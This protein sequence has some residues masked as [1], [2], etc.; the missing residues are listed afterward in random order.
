MKTVRIATRESPLALWQANHVAS[1]LTQRNPGLE[2]TL[3]KMTTEGDRFLS[4]P[5]SQVGGKGLFVKE[6]EQ[7]LIDGRADVAVHSLKDMTSVFP[8]GLILAA[9]PTRE[10]PRD[11]F[12]SPDGH[13]L[14]MLPP[15]AK[16]GTSSLRRSCILRARR[17]DLEIVSVRGNVQTRLQK[18]RDLKLAGAMLAAAGLKRLGLDHHITQVVPVAESLPAVGQGVLAIQCREAD[19][20]VRALLAP[21]EDLATRNA[22]RAERAFLAKLEGGCTV[23]LAGH[24]TVE[25]GQV[26]LRGLVGRPDGSLVVRG[27]VK[28]PVPEAERLGEALADELLSRGAGDILRDFGRREGAPRA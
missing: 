23:P 7:A 1:L 26:Y 12:C 18:T 24:A 25:D 20:D 19:A 10:D 16:V 15:G 17:P 6:I 14:A 11:A 5:L 4:A 13:T 2:V 8:E 21:L 28:G 27:E 3:V 9:V 22:V